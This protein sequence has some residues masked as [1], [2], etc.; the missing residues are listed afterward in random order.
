MSLPRA[1]GDL[2]TSCNIQIAHLT[3]HGSEKTDSGIYSG[4]IVIDCFTSSIEFAL[5]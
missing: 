4:I 1:T 2:D 5:E 3:F